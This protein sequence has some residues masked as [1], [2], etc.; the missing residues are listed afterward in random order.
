MNTY[1]SIALIVLSVLLVASVLLQQIGNGLSATF[2]G[3]GGSYQTRRGFEKV[4]FRATIVFG[5]L[6]IIGSIAYILV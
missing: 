4:L 2:G 1:I 5:I 6:I 3:A